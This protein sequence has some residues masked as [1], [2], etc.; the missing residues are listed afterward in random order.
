MSE[1][2]IAG[3]LAQFAT[4]WKELTSD[5]F[6]LDIAL[7]CHLEMVDI[8]VQK[9]IPPEI[10]MSDSE[11]NVVDEE[12]AKLLEK[13]VIEQTFHCAGEFISNIFLRKKKDNSFRMILNLKHFNKHLEYHHFKMDTVWTAI[14]LMK[15]GCFMASIDLKDAYYTVPIALE[16]RKY[17]KFTWRG[18][19]YQ[20][21]C[22]ANGLSPA[23]RYFTKLCKPVYSTLRKLGHQNVGYIDDSFLLGDTFQDCVLN[24]QDTEHLFS[25]LGFVVHDQKS[26][27]TPSQEIVFLGFVL[28]S[29]TMTVKLTHD[30]CQKVTHACSSLLQ[31]SEMTILEVA[32]VI[33]YLVSSLPGVQY[34]KLHYRI[35][36][37]EKNKALLQNK[38]NYESLM[39][40]SSKAKLDLIWWKDNVNTASNFV[41]RSSPEIEIRT[42]ASKLGWGAVCGSL[43]AQGMW[44]C[45]EKCLHINQLELLAVMFALRSFISHMCNKHVKV[46]TDN[47]TAVAYINDMGGTKSPEINEIAKQIWIWCIEN[48]VWLTACHLPGHLNVNA[49]LNSRKFNERIEWT[50]EKAVFEK[51]CSIFERPDIDLFATRI[52][53]QLEKYISWKPDPFALYVDAFTVSWNQFYFYAFPPFSLIIKC[54]NKIEREEAEGIFIAPLWPTQVWWPKLMSLVMAQPLILPR[55]QNLLSIPQKELLHPLRKKMTLIACH[56]SGSVLKRMEFQNQQPSLSCHLGGVQLKNHT[57]HTLNSGFFS[58]VKGKQIFFR[59]L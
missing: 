33:G 53:A 44:S 35:L 39:H 4:A 7:H 10:N 29:V 43:N 14:N 54:L 8:P 3:R 34:G 20:Y 50:L 21:T 47:A 15:P 36:E 46:F 56:L 58:V 19:L 59:Q 49:D 2:K 31:K 37:I 41:N 55:N 23:P 32:Q 27:R 22:M 18:K 48:N 38:G 52:N 11:M 25:K 12:L 13:G 51:I 24:V 16:H 9:F 5:N 1:I 57:V 45:T 28:N 6:V 17:L 40:L 26:V 30:K 42:D